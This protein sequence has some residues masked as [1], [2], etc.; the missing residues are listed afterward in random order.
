MM[1]TSSRSI[2]FTDPTMSVG[3]TARLAQATDAPERSADRILPLRP[4][5]RLGSILRND[6]NSW[7]EQRQDA[8]L[9][10]SVSPRQ[11]QT[12]VQTSE[13][14]AAD[15]L[16]R[17]WVGTIIATSPKPET[18]N[19]FCDL[20]IARTESDHTIRLRVPPTVAEA[21]TPRP[22]SG[23]GLLPSVT[24]GR[25][26]ELALEGTGRPTAAWLRRAGAHH[27]GAV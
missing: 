4:Y 25:Q 27:A 19:P 12:L 21:A 2:R 15:H 8:Q 23:C 22:P 17:R 14:P 18:P 13:R 9:S 24:G 1:P 10:V 3:S 20:A 26:A 11:H 5:G 7:G 16:V 6:S